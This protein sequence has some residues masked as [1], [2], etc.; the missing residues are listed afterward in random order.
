MGEHQSLLWLPD[1]C[2][3]A[4]LNVVELIGW[5]ENQAGYYWV[6][7]FGNHRGFLGEPNGWMW[8]HTATTAYTPVV[9]NGAGQTKANIWLGIKRQNRL[10]SFGNGP[11]IVAFASAGPANYSSGKGRINVLTNYVA[12]DVQFPG[13][14]HLTDDSPR[15]YGNRYYGNTEVVHPGDGTPVREDVWEYQTT[16]ATLMCKHYRWSPWRH[17][18]HL[19]HTIRKVD[20]RFAQGDP[21]TIAAHQEAVAT[22]LAEEEDDMDYRNIL[23]RIGPNRLEAL[24]LAGRW[25]GATD[26]YFDGS[27]DAVEG[28]NQN[29]V[30]V[31]I[32]S[33]QVAGLGGNLSRGDQ[34]TLN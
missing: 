11:P 23:D 21:Y 32:A 17:I 1:A 20:P 22:K 25:A 28:A 3:D 29:L 2:R 34:V 33:D 15:W 9:K 4:G 6:D 7:T 13:P 19:D 16:I 8:H 26:W 30:E 31:L 24:R 14:Q 10:W 5:E 18:G 27:S 12:L